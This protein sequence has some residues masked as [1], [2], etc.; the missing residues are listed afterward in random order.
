M[1]DDNSQ[2]IVQK[3][4]KHI[5][6]IERAQLLMEVE[7]WREALHEFNLSLAENPDEYHALCQSAVCYLR[8]LELQNAINLTKRAIEVSPEDE[9]AYRLQSLVLTENGEN[10][11]ALS[12][13]KI[14]AEKAP[15]SSDALLVLFWAQVNYG[16]IDDAEITLKSLLKLIPD[17][18]EGHEAAGFI[19]LQK[20]DYFE[21]EKH[22]LEALRINP[23]SVTALNNLG[24]VYLSLAQS[25][26]GY[27]Y[28]AKS[29]EMFERAVRAKPTFEIAQ[30]NISV[31]SSAFKVGA[32]IGIVL[33]LLIGM[34]VLFTTLSSLFDGRIRVERLM[35]FSPISSSYLHT[36]TNLVFTILLLAAIAV[37]IL[38]LFAKYREIVSYYFLN[39]RFWKLTVAIFILISILYVIGFLI[40]DS[41]SEPYT[42]VSFGFSIILVLFAL[43]N[44]SRTWA[45]NRQRLQQHL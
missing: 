44:L 10:E 34:R 31:V 41:S 39:I 38:S 35:E 7:R 25:G 18:S 17:S 33:L 19:A 16:A 32:P 30:Q 27:K 12:V 5:K 20:K 23:E 13:A 43:L 2:E 11:R 4:F 28:K 9:W 45:T 3:Y 21:S 14:A 36:F 29:A 24:V 37:G 22:Y 15:Y 42:W 6:H 8:L 26:R 40:S 1:D